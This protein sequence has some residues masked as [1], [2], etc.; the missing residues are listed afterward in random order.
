[1]HSFVTVLK[2][3]KSES[4]NNLQID[5]FRGERKYGLKDWTNV[6]T[7]NRFYIAVSKQIKL[8]V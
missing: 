1:L 3:I 6:V 2:K 7:K 4:K 5:L 8:F